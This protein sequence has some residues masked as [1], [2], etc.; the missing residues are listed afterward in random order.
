MEQLHAIGIPAGIVQKAEDLLN[1]PQLNA[2]GHFVALD[3]PEMGRCRYNGPSYQLSRTP[4]R[5]R[6]AAPLLGEH[7]TKV[8][9]MLGY[10][11]DE[12]QSL[13]DQAILV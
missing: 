4:A 6:S 2:R 13:I 10:S 5:L 11:A 12:V 9:D 3:H 8:M 1:D 7:T